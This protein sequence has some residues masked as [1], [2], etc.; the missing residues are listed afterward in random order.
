MYE[1]ICYKKPFLKEVIVRFDFPSPIT[2]LEKQLPDKISNCVRER[3]PIFEPQKTQAQELLFSGADFQATSKESMAWTFHGKEREKTLIITPTSFVITV[4]KYKTYESL[5]KDMLESAKSFFDFFPDTRSS[6]VGLRY[7][8]ILAIESGNPLAW[9]DYVDQRF[10]DIIDFHEKKE[11]LSRALHLLEYNFDGQVLKYQLGIANPDYP[12]IIR[13]KEFVLDLD[14]YCYGAF[15]LRE[16]MSLLDKAHERIQD[17]FEKS[18]T[19]TTREIMKKVKDE[20]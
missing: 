16:I 15:D 7:V 4:K 8:N 11:H 17:F 20:E 5:Q 1:D 10:L 12:A 6:R 19:D 18:I 3:F 9:A 13:R 14:S 2:E